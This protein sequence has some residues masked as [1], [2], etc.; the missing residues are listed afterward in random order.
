MFC[1][2]GGLMNYRKNLMLTNPTRILGDYMDGP[3]SGL[4]RVGSG[5]HVA[6]ME[7]A[8]TPHGPVEHDQ[9]EYSWDVASLG[10]APGAYVA[11]FVSHAG[12]RDRGVGCISFAVD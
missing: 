3:T 1:G 5:V 9:S 8:P 12:D 11:E 6:G 4:C 10:L 2:D 7:P